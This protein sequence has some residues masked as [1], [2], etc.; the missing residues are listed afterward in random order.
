MILRFDLDAL[1]TFAEQLPEYS[2]PG[3]YFETYCRRWVK[4]A[5]GSTGIADGMFARF[6]IASAT[7]ASR[8]VEREDHVNMLLGDAHQEVQNCRDAYMNADINAI[9]SLESA[10]GVRYSEGAEYLSRYSDR[11]SIE[12]PTLSI[13]EPSSSS[14]IPD[15]WIQAVSILGFGGVVGI[16]PTVVQLIPV[17]SDMVTSLEKFLA[18]DWNL[19][20]RSSNA[21]ICLSMHETEHVDFLNTKVLAV[22]QTWEGNAAES[23]HNW[24]LTLFSAMD[25]F[26]LAID[27]AAEQFEQVAIGMQLNAAA[28][29]G[30]LGVLAALI[31]AAVGLTG[32]AVVTAGVTLLGL[33]ETI[34]GALM[35]IETIL[36]AIGLGIVAIEGLLG[37]A[38]TKFASMGLD[39]LISNRDSISS[40]R[41]FDGPSYQ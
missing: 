20:M 18:G 9:A 28:I 30:L 37:I 21:L 26:A 27:D 29:G 11:R 35:T 3:G 23:A 24:F 15:L 25:E 10:Y 14:G 17:I 41:D 39:G 13:D 22:M 6:E 32:A 2:G 38:Q 19:A 12:N 1:E 4:V 34:A 7:V 5:G 16:P 8:V 31:A 36:S 33:P 40:L